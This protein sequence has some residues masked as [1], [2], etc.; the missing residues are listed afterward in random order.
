M[1]ATVVDW[2]FWGADYNPGWLGGVNDRRAEVFK[3]RRAPPSP[4]RRSQRVLL[5][6]WALS[7]GSATKA[8]TRRAPS[9]VAER[10]DSHHS[11]LILTF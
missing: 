3:T 1:D 11:A 7:M 4:R 8:A 9:I 2:W 5:T 10:S 6:H